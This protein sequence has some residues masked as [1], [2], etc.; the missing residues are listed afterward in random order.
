MEV[1]ILPKRNKLGKFFGFVRF[2]EVEDERIF[3]VKLD[4]VIINGKKIHANLPCFN[5]NDFVSSNAG[6]TGERPRVF[7]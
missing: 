3:A 4:N 7:P 6:G 2:K 5:K 1:V